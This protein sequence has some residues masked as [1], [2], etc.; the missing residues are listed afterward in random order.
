MSWTSP[1]LADRHIGMTKRYN[2]HLRRCLAALIIAASAGMAFTTANTVSRTRVEAE[3]PLLAHSNVPEPV[4]A[5]LQRACQDCHSANTVWPWYSHVPVLSSRI[6][7]DV[8][9]GRAF[10]DFSK[11]N[12]YSDGERR[13]FTTAIGAAVGGGLMP[14]PQYLW[15]H[16]GARLSSTDL[17]VVQA[18]VLT[19][20]KTRR[21]PQH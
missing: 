1:L 12:D 8:D 11:W 21:S 20:S 6:H 16:R 3:S 10:L 13:G 9:K 14:P 17:Q 7:E 18:W 4:R 2:S 5:V 19:N 15:I